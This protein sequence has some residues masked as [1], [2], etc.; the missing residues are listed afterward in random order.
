M[1]L[2]KD[3][4]EV[5]SDQVSKQAVAR[6]LAH[7]VEDLEQKGDKE[8]VDKTQRETEKLTKTSKERSGKNYRATAQEGLEKKFRTQKAALQAEIDAVLEHERESK[9]ERA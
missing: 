4:K 5:A 1:G 2:S 8:R 3:I 6:S 7:D 9:K